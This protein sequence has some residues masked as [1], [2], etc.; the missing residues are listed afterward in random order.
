MLSFGHCTYV[1]SRTTPI[2]ALIKGW[3]YQQKSPMSGPLSDAMQQPWSIAPSSAIDRVELPYWL[4][5][6]LTICM[7]LAQL[8][9][10]LRRKVVQSA[11]RGFPLDAPEQS[12]TSN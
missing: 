8:L 7:P 3:H 4:F 5:W 11:G 9:L 2:A 6:L 1:K 10:R 12:T